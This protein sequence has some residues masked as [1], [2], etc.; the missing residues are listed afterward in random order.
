MHT[1]GGCRAA[2]AACLCDFSRSISVAGWCAFGGTQVTHTQ[3][4]GPLCWE[5]AVRI[6][7]FSICRYQYKYMN[8]LHGVK[9]FTLQ[10]WPYV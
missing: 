1:V 10:Y 4:K 7:F 8:R 6:D 9:L 5:A 2:E 3:T